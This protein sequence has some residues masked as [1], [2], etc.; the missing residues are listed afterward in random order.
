MH[1]SGHAWGSGRVHAR[2]DIDA[3]LAQAQSA[4]GLDEDRVYRLLGYAQAGR[5]TTHGTHVLDL[6]AGAEAHETSAPEIV[7]VQLPVAAIEDVSCASMTPYLLDAVRFALA[8]APVASTDK[9]VVV[10]LSLG[11]IAG[12]KDGHSLLE[13]A[14]DELL[15]LRTDLRIVLSEGNALQSQTHAWAEMDP[16]TEVAL[17]WRLMPDD[18]SSSFL[19]FWLRPASRDSTGNAPIDFEVEV[20][21]P[22]GLPALCLRLDTSRN[23]RIQ[24]QLMDE[25]GRV[26]A[27]LGLHHR[28]ANGCYP[29]A[30]LTVAPTTRSASW[31]WAAPH[32]HWSL[33]VRNQGR[34]LYCNVYAQR[35]D[36]SFGRRGK[37]RQGRLHDDCYQRFDRR[38]GPAA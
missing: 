16:D 18:G 17:S 38:G 25:Q 21:P 27:A 7:G 28:P 31:P 4:F 8:L 20:Q 19:E 22:G 34:P 2:A 10:N 30:L 9:P 15:A 37:G 32:G 12:P 29:M 11:N 23:E 36:A 1:T 13:S 35:D 26:L 6:A 33:Q 14:F 5:R 3:A 24:H